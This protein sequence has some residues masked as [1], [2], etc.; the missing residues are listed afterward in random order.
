MKRI[1]RSGNYVVPLDYERNFEKAL[2]TFKFQTIFNPDTNE[3][4]QLNDPSKHPLGPLLLNYEDL[5][6]L[7]DYKLDKELA[8][9]ICRGEIDPIRKLEFTH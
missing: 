4:K 1:R 3:L 8:I 9:K 5:S 7:G 2:L 6:F